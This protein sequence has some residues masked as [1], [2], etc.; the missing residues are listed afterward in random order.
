MIRLMDKI[1][2]EKH[3]EQYPWIKYHV[4][5]TL[6]STKDKICEKHSEQ[7]QWIK[8]YVKSTLNSTNG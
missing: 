4:K 6:N 2:R 5:S 1:L 7:Y 3:F 8:Y